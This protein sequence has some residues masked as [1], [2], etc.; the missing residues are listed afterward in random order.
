V[1]E[2]GNDCLRADLLGEAKYLEDT[3]E[4]GFPTFGRKTLIQ[5]ICGSS[6]R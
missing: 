2:K 1:Q 5:V 6:N 4:I 3:I